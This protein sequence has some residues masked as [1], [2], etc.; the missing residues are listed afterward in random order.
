[1]L[2]ILLVFCWLYS[3]GVQWTG[4]LA[5]P[6]QHAE[7]QVGHISPPIPR[8][9][10]PSPMIGVI[11]TSSLATTSS[12]S[13]SS[14]SSHVMTS[15]AGIASPSSTPTLFS[16]N[17]VK[18]MTTC[19]PGVITWTYNGSSANILLFISNIN[20]ADPYT[21]GGR[22]RR[23]NTAGKS[24]SV[25]LANISATL[26]SWTWSQVTQPQG[27]YT[28]QGSVASLGASS[29]PFFISNGTDTACLLSSSSSSTEPTSTASPTAVQAY[30]TTPSTGEI[31]GIVVGSLAG[32]VIP[33]LAIACYLRR[34]RRPAIRSRKPKV[35]NVGRWSSLKSNDSA[36][37]SLAEG[38]AGF[39][40]S[41]G[42]SESTG[43]ILTVAD[44]GKASET[45]TPLGS[46]EYH[47]E[48]KVVHPQSPSGMIPLDDIDTPLSR[49]DRRI[50]AYSIQDPSFRGDA[51]RTRATSSRHSKQGLELQAARI[52]SSM[53]SSMYLRTER[54]SLPAIAAPTPHTPT[55][56][57]RGRDEY[58]PSPIAASLRRSP[59]AGAA[60]AR[61]SSRKP[62][63][64]YDASEFR[65]DLRGAADNQ[66]T[67]TA[68]ESSHSHGTESLPPLHG[69]SGLSHNRMHY[70]IPD[71]PP[72]RN[73]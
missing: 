63:P 19:A 41:H 25:I 9:P 60:S 73:E 72:P 11:L 15:T 2:S 61:R 36:A 3:T 64:H 46:D 5:Q 59:S 30:S 21:Q 69:V 55:S 37:R 18:N 14:T 57:S 51:G 22:T 44:S 40:H 49:H 53:E 68:G 16:I 6:A 62:V 52:R 4:V 56:P 20:V 48:E 39:T 43:E 45:T 8:A 65:D 38:N 47:G 1:M 24:V 54:F 42:H 32:L 27:W 7:R 71:M 34:R 26:N 66:S 10:D 33:A 58:P 28:I 12:T 50:S 29:D 17:A 35:Q 13:S 70:L 67:I 23:Q 31:V